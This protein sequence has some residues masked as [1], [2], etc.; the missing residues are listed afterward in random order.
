MQRIK[1]FKT[2]DA[3]RGLAALWVVMA[4]SVAPWIGSGNEAQLRSPL[5]AFSIRG[6]LGV[7]IFFVISGYCIFA[8]AYASL[9]SGKTIQRYCFERVRRIYPPYFAALVITA[10]SAAATIYVASHHL[11]A[12][13]L[14]SGSRTCS[15]CNLNCTPIP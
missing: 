7:S 11:I 12:G 14:C 4:H 3:F 8:A 10:L 1:P 9:V 2:L 13:M 5:Y 6:Q 15:F